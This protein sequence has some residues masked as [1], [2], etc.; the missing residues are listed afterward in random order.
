MPAFA[1]LMIQ[2]PPPQ[3][4]V[5]CSPPSSFDNSLPPPDLSL[6]L[7]LR[8]LVLLFNRPDSS[9]ATAPRSLL[10]IG[11]RRAIPTRNFNDTTR[12]QTEYFRLHDSN[13]P[14]PGQRIVHGLLDDDANA[15]TSFDISVIMEGNELRLFKNNYEACVEARYEAQIKHLTA[16]L[17]QAVIECDTKIISV[18]HRSLMAEQDAM[19][20]RFQL[21]LQQMRLQV[22]HAEA[23]PQE[24]TE[25]P[26]DVIAGKYSSELRGALDA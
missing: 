15:K 7:A 24:A 6:Q 4:P 14:D 21:H 10:Q 13:S 23:A 1:D 11:D 17:Q 25:V 12:H 19:N 9:Q 5:P 22:A 26:T 8:D 18:A 20:H 16:S 3:K 2:S